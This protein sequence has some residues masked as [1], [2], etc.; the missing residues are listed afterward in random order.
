[1][2]PHGFAPHRPTGILATAMRV[3]GKLSFF[4][5]VGALG[6]AS[7]CLQTT[8]PDDFGGAGAGT[9]DV[10]GRTPSKEP[11]TAEATFDSEWRNITSNLAGMDSECGNLT[12]VDASP[13]EDRL[14]AGVALHGLWESSDGGESWE[15]LGQGSNSEP[16]ELRPSALTFD[17]DDHKTFWVNGIYGRLGVYETRDDGKTFIGRG[18]IR[19]NDYIAVDFSDPDRQL[20]FAGGHETPQALWRTLDGGETWE[21]MGEKIPDTYGASSVPFLID[22]DVV[23]LGAYEWKG[24]GAILRSENGGLKWKR[25][26]DLPPALGR[27]IRDL[28]GDLWWSGQAALYRSGDNGATWDVIEPPDDLRVLGR[29]LVLVEDQIGVATNMGVAL[30]D[31]DRETWTLVTPKFPF[32]PSDLRYSEIRDAFLV[33]HFDCGMKVLDDA[34]AIYDR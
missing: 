7:G 8:V 11:P 19:H 20:I 32:Q 4:G 9:R 10:P 13:W 24:E 21:T 33:S 6:S 25:V 17:P 27:P 14:F 34:I 31:A 16:I 2:L 5:L 26:L 30:L 3:L 15:Q 18:D 28:Q 22:K 29:G 23:L 12:L 1:M